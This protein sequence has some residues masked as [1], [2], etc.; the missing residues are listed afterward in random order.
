M[1]RLLRCSMQKQVV[2]QGVY[3]HLRDLDSQFRRAI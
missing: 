1:A 2:Q 3:M